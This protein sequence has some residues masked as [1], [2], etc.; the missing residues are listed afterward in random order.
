MGYILK[1]DVAD[2]IN[3]KYKN[4]YIADKLNL[5]CTYISQILHRKRTIAK[6]IAYAFVKTID[7]E[8][9][10]EDMFDRIK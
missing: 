10:I 4:S 5:S 1:E 8:A 6:H 9:E 7:S 2:A 3:S